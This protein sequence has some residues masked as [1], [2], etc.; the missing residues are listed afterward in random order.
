[1]KRR[2]RY[3]TTEVAEKYSVSSKGVLLKRSAIDSGACGQTRPVEHEF[4]I[5]WKA[6]RKCP[7]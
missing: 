1:M 2:R 4:I 3:G 7:G 5:E 6:V